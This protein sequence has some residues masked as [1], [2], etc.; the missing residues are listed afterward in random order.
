MI[1]IP[2]VKSPPLKAF[3]PGT[4]GDGEIA[5]LENYEIG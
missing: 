4:R 5:F 1:P 3:S 2:Y